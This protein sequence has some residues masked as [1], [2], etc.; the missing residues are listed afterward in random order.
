MPD[1]NRLSQSRYEE[2]DS[3]RGLAAL[4]VMAHHFLFIFPFIHPYQNIHHPFLQVIT[5]SP[6]HLFW[7]GYESV[8]LFFVLS[9]F[10]LSLPFNGGRAPTYRSFIIKR[11]FRIYFPYLAAILL[12]VGLMTLFSRGGIEGLS[13]WFNS[14]W[15]AFDLRSF[16]KH[17][18]LIALPFNEAGRYDPVVW[19]LAIEMQISI[20]FPFLFLAVFFFGW[21]R[22]LAGAALLAW[23]SYTTGRLPLLRYVPAFIAGVLLARAREELISAYRK[24]T[25]SQRI[26]WFVSA[27]VCYCVQW[28]AYSEEPQRQYLNDCLITLGASMFIVTALG[29]AKASRALLL[30]PL[31][32]VGKI[33]YS[34]YLYHAIVLFTLVNLLYGRIPIGFILGLSVVVTFAVSSL[35]YFCIERTCIHWGKVLANPIEVR[36]RVN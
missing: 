14:T 22:A 33:S 32:F 8:L 6:L 3:L 23:L 28:N 2:L 11:I 34:I 5:F 26:F 20:L 36:T 27:I 9:G 12:A 25:T 15:L 31:V 18:S 21:K 7:T 13:S 10:V 19:S 24:F 29:S 17:L 30:G 16:L 4:A 1:T 35:S